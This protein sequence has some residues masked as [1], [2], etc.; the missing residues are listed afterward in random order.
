[1]VGGGFSQEVDPPSWL[2]LMHLITRT[3]AKQNFSFWGVSIFLLIP[4]NHQVPRFAV[5][6]INCGTDF[7][8]STRHYF[9]WLVINEPKL[10]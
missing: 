4:S 2:D 3:S 1:M 8:A 6:P 5:T 9:D 7:E 10:Q